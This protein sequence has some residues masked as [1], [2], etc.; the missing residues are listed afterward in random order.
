M[1]AKD[2]LGAIGLGTPFYFA[3]ATYGFFLWLD[4][5]AS[6]PANRAI[7][8]WLKNEQYRQVDVRLAIVAAFD[9]LPIQAAQVR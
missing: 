5:S 7:S 8:G 9:S 4:R 2:I 6:A 1:A 3:G